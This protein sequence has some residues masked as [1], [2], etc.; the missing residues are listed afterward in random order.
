M[1]TLLVLFIILVDPVAV[2]RVLLVFFALV[3]VV[4]RLQPALRLKLRLGPEAGLRLAHLVEPLA[5]GSVVFVFK[6]LILLVSG[7]L[8]L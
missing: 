8:V 4:S 3:R 7:V 6:D 2:L 5:S 1:V